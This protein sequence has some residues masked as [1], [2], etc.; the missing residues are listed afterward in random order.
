M[1]TL[2]LDLDDTLL[3]SNIENFIPAY[4]QALSESLKEMVS[5]EVMIKALMGG[6][7][8]MMAKT[9]PVHTLK[10][11]FDEY[12]YKEISVDP[13]KIQQKIERF[14]D[15]VFPTLNS[16]TKQIPQAIEFVKWA[17]NQ[18]FRVVIATNPLFP[19]KAIHHRLRWAGLAPEDFPYELVTS[20]ETMHFT[21]EN[22]S[23]FPE[24]L[25]LMGWPDDPVIMVGNDI[26][27]DINPA[28]QS[29]IKGFWINEGS[30]GS[31]DYHEIPQGKMGDLQ[32]WLE[33][34][35]FMTF[36]HSLDEPSALVATLRSTPAVLDGLLSN[37]IPE[38]DD[39]HSETNGISIY[40]IICDL[41]DM[42]VNVN[43]PRIRN[44]LRLDCPFLVSEKS[45]DNSIQE[46]DNSG[47]DVQFALEGFNNARRET[48]DLVEGL[49]TEW[50]RPVRSR[51]NGSGTFHEMVA[52]IVIHDKKS[53]QKIFKILSSQK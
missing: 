25:G 31:K 14:Y 37:I 11:V 7:R 45:I 30:N 50:S 19:I 49:S 51:T 15:D 32:K 52:E 18:K 47:Q 38:A 40:K 26:N 23:Y 29:G 9:D 44:V 27:M 17:F 21:K 24:I 43:L 33:N 35:S 46:R 53:I 42:E 8:R 34:I 12:F 3:S 41:R 10:I 39:F 48:I 16:L 13:W 28:R 1:L 36:K 4:F 20:Y 5:P 22:I 6:T 2:L